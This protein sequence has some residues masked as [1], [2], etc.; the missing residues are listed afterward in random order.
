MVW[1]ISAG[2]GIVA[3]LCA[4]VPA[5]VAALRDVR[6][7]SSAVT[8]ETLD[9]KALLLGTGAQRET[10]AAQRETAA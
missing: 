5:F 10:A 9:R 3:I 8:P 4:A 6:P 7:R 2:F 1:A